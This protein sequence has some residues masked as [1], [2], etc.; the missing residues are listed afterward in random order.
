MTSPQPQPAPSGSVAAGVLVAAE[1]NFAA[2]LAAAVAA[3]WTIDRIIGLL[4]QFP[5]VKPEAAGW[6]L[7]DLMGERIGIGP[8]PRPGTAAHGMYRHNLHRRASYLI[9]AARRLS[10]AVL[11]GQ[12]A[13]AI[14]REQ[15]YLRNHRAATAKRMAAAT[16]VDQVR[17]RTPDSSLLG[18]QAVLDAKT[19]PTC[20][21]LHGTNFDPLDPPLVEGLPALPG[22]VHPFCR[23]TP[24]PAWPVPTVGEAA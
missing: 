6:L 10:S 23:C 4:T 7:I 24:R 13:S 18:W 8:I 12:V 15:G 2:Q 1:L 5:G 14:H 3:V 11:L 21:R 20:R 16:V 22:T 19:D 17:G 9:N